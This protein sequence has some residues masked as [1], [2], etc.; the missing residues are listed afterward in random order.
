MKKAAGLLGRFIKGRGRSAPT[1]KAPSATSGKAEMSAAELD[2][3]FARSD[4]YWAAWPGEAAL[5]ADGDVDPNDQHLSMSNK[6]IME[7][8]KKFWNELWSWYMKDLQAHAGDIKMLNDAIE[9][10][11]KGGTKALRGKKL[12]KKKKKPFPPA[13]TDGDGANGDGASKPAAFSQLS[14]FDTPDDLWSAFAAPDAAAEPI[15]AAPS[16]T[17]SGVPES[18]PDLH[19]KA[20]KLIKKLTRHARSGQAGSSELNAGLKKLK[21]FGTDH[22]ESAARALGLGGPLGGRAGSKCKA[23]K[24]IAAHLKTHAKAAACE[25]HAAAGLP[26]DG[27]QSVAVFDGL[28]RTRGWV[29]ASLVVSGVAPDKANELAR[30]A[31]EFSLGSE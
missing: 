7:L 3:I 11:R 20:L 14:L 30:N 31:A 22:I 28:P 25:L 26:A 24:R 13:E 2:A 10:G 27:D 18:V 15:H 21:R 12:K 16:S 17:P 8:G 29:A 4:L 5:F 9:T 19:A 23:M 1:D 6:E